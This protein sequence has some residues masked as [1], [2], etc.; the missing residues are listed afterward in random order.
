MDS[1]FLVMGLRSLLEFAQAEAQAKAEG[2][3]VTV[4]ELRKAR[5]SWQ[6]SD[7]ELSKE[8][9]IAEEEGR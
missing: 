7:F 5:D 3:K 6:E 8:I 4:E 9:E 2:R 1:V